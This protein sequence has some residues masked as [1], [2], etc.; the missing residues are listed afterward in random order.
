MKVALIGASGNAGSRILAE[1]VRRGHS[2]T[3]I[4]RHPEK[5]SAEPNVTPK[6]GDVF[7]GE[8]LADLLK[9]HDAVI[10]SVHFLASDPDVLIEAVRASGVKRYLVVGGAGSLEVAPGIALVT[11]PDFPSAYKAEAVKGGDF[12]KRLR[13]IDDLD[14]TFLSPSALFVPGERTG[15]FRLGK[16]EL[17]TN[18]R[19]SS[20]SFEDYA[21]A[22]VDEVENPAHIRQRFTVGY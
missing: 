7:D 2:V 12:L 17:L 13:G 18:D 15:Q 19:G 16:D 11:T 4:A 14:W 3:A 5:I 22:L 10:S 20:I 21:V 1:L 8:G 6:K 9:G